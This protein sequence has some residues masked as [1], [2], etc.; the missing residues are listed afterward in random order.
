M[1]RRALFAPLLAV[2]LLSSKLALPAAPLPRASPELSI[3]EPTGEN[4]KLSSF[5][6]KVV[7][8]EFLFVRS[9]H[10]VR[11]A[12]MLNKLQAELGPRGFQAIAIAFDAPNSTVTGGDYLISMA[13]SLMLSYPV[14]Y[15]QKT[16]VDAYLGRSGKDL[17]AIP[18]IIVIDRMGVIRAATGGQTNPILEDAGA[19][20]T[21]LQPLLKESPPPDKK[22]KT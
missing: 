15:A 20:R 13:D 6:G 11:V 19:L 9:Q 22:S 2:G 3:D 8:L 18:Q 7:V 14:G 5:K 12:Q 1:N 4:L 16:S 21:L 17:L 10:C